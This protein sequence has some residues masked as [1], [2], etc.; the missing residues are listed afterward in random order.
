M[1][2]THKHLWEKVASLGNLMQAAN[3]AMR[4]KRSLAPAA[5]F[6]AEWELEC[7]NLAEEL[8]NGSY[9]PG[10]Y[11][12]L[13]CNNNTPTNENNNVGFRVARPPAVSQV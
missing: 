4:G 5:G 10:A 7:V 6:F 9:Q 3:L 2:K 12:Y 8:E 1:A 13:N 11:R